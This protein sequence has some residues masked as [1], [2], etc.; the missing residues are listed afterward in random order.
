MALT[1]FNKHNCHAM[2]N[3]LYPPVEMSQPTSKL[4]I[5]LL[6]AQR[7]GFFNYIRTVER[8]G[9][10][11]LQTLM[12]QGAKPGDPNG[13]PAVKRTLNNYLR[14]ANS[15]ILESQDISS[16][17]VVSYTCWNTTPE[18]VHTHSMTCGSMESSLALEPVQESAQE[19]EEE[20]AKEPN[21]PSTANTFFITEKL[22]E[23]SSIGKSSPQITP[24]PFSPS[25]TYQHPTNKPKPQTDSGISFGS[26]ARHSKHP[27]T[28]S[29]RSGGSATGTGSRHTSSSSTFDFGRGSTLERLARE[30]RKLSIGRK[31]VADEIIP[32]GGGSDRFSHIERK[33][34][35]QGAVIVT[36]RDR[37]ES[38]G[39]ATLDTRSN[40]G[41]VTSGKGREPRGGLFRSDSSASKSR[42]QLEGTQAYSSPTKSRFPGLRKMKSFGDF[43]GAGARSE[44]RMGSTLKNM[45]RS[46]TNLKASSASASARSS[47]DSQTPLGTP[48]PLSAEEMRRKRTEFEGRGLRNVGGGFI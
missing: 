11:C 44:S 27:S 38:S 10:M 18:L 23:L 2:L 35:G 46:Q 5:P 45:G 16:L 24:Q 36:G 39:L 12:Q 4:T 37:A 13:W 31:V 41:F 22:P 26:D 20:L 33:L 6:K 30:L 29:S 32:A 8:Q 1:P 7:E 19:Q 28:S 47:E 34:Q 17:E 14:L 21:P 15:M 25:S 3:T 48:T 9:P 43:S 42:Q 40:L